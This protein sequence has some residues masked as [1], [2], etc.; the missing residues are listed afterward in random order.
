ML[1]NCDYFVYSTQYLTTLDSLCW[2][3]TVQSTQ[4]SNVKPGQFT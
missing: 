3:F 4:L 1:N 2:G